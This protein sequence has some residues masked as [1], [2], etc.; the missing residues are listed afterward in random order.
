MKKNL[1]SEIC[2]VDKAKSSFCSSL[3]QV[4]MRWLSE[5]NNGSLVFRSK[6][7]VFQ[8]VLCSSEVKTEP[9]ALLYNPLIRC[10][11]NLLICRP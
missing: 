8:P 5:E 10:V 7:L 1:F 4:K 9:V 3:P 11:S 2:E 6:W